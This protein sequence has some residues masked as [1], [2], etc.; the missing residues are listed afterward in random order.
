LPNYWAYA[1]NFVLHDHMFEPVA[2]FSFPAHLYLVSGW[3]ATCSTPN[4]AKSCVNNPKFPSFLQPGGGQTVATPSF[5][6]TDLTYLL[7]R[8][9]VSW[10]YYVDNATGPY[11]K[12]AGPTCQT[13]RETGT[14]MIWNV[15]PFF[16]TVQQDHQA[17]NIQK[18]S[19]FYSDARKGALP[20]VTWIAPSGANSEHPA[21]PIS[22]G[23]TYVTSL[24]DAVMRSPDWSSSAIFL[25]W[26]DWGGFYDNVNPPRVDG[27]GYGLRVPS[28]VISPYARKGFIDHQTLSFDAYLKFIEDDFLDRQRLNPKTDGRPDP[29][30]DVRENSPI[31]GDLTRDFN[32]SQKPRAPLILPTLP[33]TDLLGA[34]AMQQAVIGKGRTVP[35]VCFQAGTVIGKKGSTL[36][37]TDITGATATVTTTKA[38]KYIAGLS[39]P[40]AASLIRTGS[41]V[42]IRGTRH[43]QGQGLAATVSVT[44]H[45]VQVLDGVCPPFSG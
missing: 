31:L 10:R 9:H 29:R 19:T 39:I 30:P 5:A 38:T 24:I 26:D 25:A 13:L 42:Y 20:S 3:S 14:P 15:L 12:A 2:S 17:G 40:G 27:N 44:A 36:T 21:G 33:K 8:R 7:D 41:S 11:C 28:L 23:Q 22:T 4:L 34:S 18:L 37:V 35:S 45:S 43:T 1:K 16:T 32:F 6:W